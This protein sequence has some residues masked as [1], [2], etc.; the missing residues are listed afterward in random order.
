MVAW[1]LAAGCGRRDF[2]VLNDAAVSIDAPSPNAVARRARDRSDHDRQQRGPHRH[3][4]ACGHRRGHHQYRPPYLRAAEWSQCL[5]LGS[6]LG[7]RGRHR[8]RRWRR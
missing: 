4:R 8:S 7:W 6:Q 3:R 2:D 1:V 5:V